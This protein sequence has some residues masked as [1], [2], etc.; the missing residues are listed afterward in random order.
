M[1]DQQKKVVEDIILNLKYQAS[2]LGISVVY[3]SA[4]DGTIAANAGF[5]NIKLYRNYTYQDA[6][7]ELQ[8]KINK[9][10]LADSVTERSDWY[11]ANLV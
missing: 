10:I 7:T 3:Y 8:N 5:S 6:I 1:T 9:K 2:N 4:A 11:T